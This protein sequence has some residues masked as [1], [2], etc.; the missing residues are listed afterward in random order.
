MKAI[1]IKYPWSILICSGCKDIENRTWN[2]NYRGR[3]FIHESKNIQMNLSD[4]QIS[5][6][7]KNPFINQI[8]ILG[9]KKGSSA[10]IGSVDIIDCIVGDKKNGVWAEYG[11]ADN[12]KPIMNWKLSN[13]ILYETPI[14]AKGAL[15]FWDSGLNEH[16]VNNNYVNLI[17]MVSN[18]IVHKTNIQYYDFK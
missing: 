4:S 11:F 2:T 14:P 16:I 9:K 6:L 7:K 5:E 1:S 3:V 15:S 8:I 10:I 12:S 13:P 17:D 18:K